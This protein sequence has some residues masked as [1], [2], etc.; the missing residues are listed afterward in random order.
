MLL[1][2]ICRLRDGCLFMQ[3]P[4]KPLYGDA[5]LLAV[6]TRSCPAGVFTHRTLFGR[7]ARS[8][9]SGFW[10][11]TLTMTR[12]RMALRPAAAARPSRWNSRHSSRSAH[13]WP[14]RTCSNSC[15]Y[16]P[17]AGRTDWWGRGRGCTSERP[18]RIRYRT[19]GGV[20]SIGMLT[21]VEPFAR[22]SLATI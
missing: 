8:S 2:N 19:D 10:R 11:T 4:F 18:A 9:T 3:P 21:G 17:P 12:S 22:D 5:L 1:E 15:R 7:R 13:C 20:K 14:T 6:L 16:G